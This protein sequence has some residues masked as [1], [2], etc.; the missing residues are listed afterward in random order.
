MN[1]PVTL[2]VLISDDDPMIRAALR[3]VL[4]AGCALLAPKAVAA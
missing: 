4:D 3:E 2:R 1:R